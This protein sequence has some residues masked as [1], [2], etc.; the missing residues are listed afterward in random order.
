[1]INL[2][3]ELNKTR[4]N[5]THRRLGI[6]YAI[7]EEQK[8]LISLGFI[9]NALA[10]E[11]ARILD[12]PE[13][14]AYYLLAQIAGQDTTKKIPEVLKSYEAWDILADKTLKT[15]GEN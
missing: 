14:A 13:I 1:M 8:R 7:D 5:L 4:K 11:D 15:V 9:P 10:N 6:N 12:I 3:A 2:F